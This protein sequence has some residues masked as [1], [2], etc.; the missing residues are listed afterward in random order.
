[1]RKYVLIMLLMSLQLVAYGQTIAILDSLGLPHPTTV[2]SMR[3][4]IDDDAGSVRS[5]P[6]T[7][8]THLVDLSSLQEGL[9]TIHYQ[10]VDSENKVA[11]PYSAVFWVPSKMAQS[12]MATTLR[13]WF[14]DADDVQTC[15][16]HAGVQTLDVANL[17]NGLHTLHYQVVDEQGEVSYIAS[18]TFLKLGSLV[19]SSTAATLRYWFDDADDVRTCSAHAGVQ[20]LDVSGLLNGLHTLHYQVVDTDGDMSYVATC[21]FLK[22]E[23]GGA[24]EKVTVSKLI[25]WY[26]D[27]Q[28]LTTVSMPEGVL[29]L[30]VSNMLEGLHTIHYMVVCSDGTITSSRSSVFLKTNI[31]TEASTAKRMR[32][33]FDEKIAVAEI[34]VETGA[35]TLDVSHLLDGLHTVH[36]Q[37]VDDKGLL[38]AP[39]TGVFL[40][41]KEKTPTAAQ[42]LK[43]WFDDEAEAKVADVAG[44]AQTIDASLLLDGLHVV[45]YQL[46]DAKGMA[47]APVSDLFVKMVDRKVP[48]GDNVI[49]RYTYWMNDNSTSNKKV[50]IENPTSPYQ[51][52]ALLPMMKAPVR[53]SKFHFETKTGKPIIYAK[54]TFHVRFED[55]LGY[56]ADDSRDFVDYS[57][58]QKVDVVKKLTDH[59]GREPFVKPS[60][61]TIR[62]Y[63]M[64]CEKGDSIALQSSQ[65]SSVQIFA[66]S[67]EE[68]FS[69]SGSE[70]IKMDGVHARENGTYYFAIHDVTGSRSEMA[71]AY[72][73]IDKYAV[74]ST[75]S[76]K[77]GVMPC[78]QIL[79]LDGNGFDNLKSAML[80]KGDKR[81]LVDSIGTAGKAKGRLYMKLHG[82]EPYG[83]Y[84]LVLNFD[85]GDE[86]GV[87]V[88]ENLVDFEAPNF[89]DIKITVKDPQIVGNPYPVTIE[90]TNTSNISYQA[91]PFYFGVDHLDDIQNVKYKNFAIECNKELCDSGLQLK[92][93]YDNFRGNNSKTKIVPSIIPELLPGETKSF[94][95]DVL[96]KNV[97]PFNVYA[98][99]ETPWNLKGPEASEFIEQQ[100]IP[101][102]TG[103]FTG[104]TFDPCDIASLF[105]KVKE[106]CLCATTLSLG[107]TIGGIQNA[108]QNRHNQALR[109]QMV[110]A[111]FE[112][113]ADE[114]F[115]PIRLPSPPDLMWYWLQ[116]CLPGMLGKATTVFN[117]QRQIISY[118]EC[119]IPSG[120]PVTP[121]RSYDPNEMHGY[122]SEAGSVY[123]GK[124]VKKVNYSIEFENDPKLASAAAHRIVVCDTLDSKVFDLSSFKAT[125]VQIGEKVLELDGEQNLTKTVDMRPEIN[126]IAQVDLKYDADKGVA[127]WTVTS[128]DPMSMEETLDVTQ[129]VLPVNSN[130]NGIGFL[131]FDIG[132]KKAMGDGEPFDNRAAIIFD[133]NEAILTPVW[134]N[135]VDSIAPMSEIVSVSAKDSLITL[136]FDGYDNRS[137][138]WKYVLYVQDVEGGRWKKLEDVITTSEYVYHGNMGFDYGFCVLAVDSAGNVEQKEL[139]R[140]VSQATFKYGDANSDGI[141]NSIDVSLAV[142]FYSVGTAPLNFAATDVNKD[143]VINSIDVAKIVEIYTSSSDSKLKRNTKK[144]RS[145]E[146]SK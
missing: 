4:W 58:S 67:G 71:L 43:Y 132:L 119:V 27:Q 136:R 122:L 139:A 48:N 130:G 120:H 123:V 69:T 131:N 36:Y 18:T 137:G 44:G 106:E 124:H 89:N 52:Y 63:A 114:F 100:Q 101:D 33:W 54:N 41:L 19:Q 127:Q 38:T 75:S 79:G 30:D 98:W 134:T 121:R 59:V 113:E 90:V 99:V 77:F 81:I 88:C 24:A 37:L 142:E 108:L 51:L 49:T 91:T 144:R 78:V 112:D 13:Y 1:M 66:P 14:D 128:L 60:D 93:E 146:K 29:T 86:P 25:Y 39:M 57:V 143:G 42:S 26:D 28:E 80:V 87:I 65:P 56:W 141:V 12:P 103:I 126:A 104:C 32:Y 45:H 118:P 5:V 62:W 97:L 17:L 11:A 68:V 31:D 10:I 34:A 110:Q 105:D 129:G 40:K 102:V 47:C 2:K 109:E 9:H 138:L 23:E 74:L 50:S 117:L 107:G 92:Y 16:A 20:T 3:Y 6:K 70:S 73:H 61:N 64:D 55:A 111:G 76:S 8:G 85:D 95:L 53:S 15:S 133:Q 21:V 145:K 96:L 46:I 115:R 135:V 94:V 125:R 116:H 22:L 72:Q 82:D 84:N 7:N 83:K 140:E 35:Q